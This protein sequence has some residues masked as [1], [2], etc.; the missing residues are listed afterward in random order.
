MSESSVPF[1]VSRLPR[2]IVGSSSPSWWGTTTFMV[3]EGMALLLCAGS[4]L[5]LARH[6]DGTPP[7]GVP[8]PDV[9]LPTVSMV[10]LLFTLWP[11]RLVYKAS[12]QRD[13][14]A[15]RNALLLL[16]LASLPPTVLRGFEFAALNV[17]WDTTAYGS[18]VWYILGF[19]ATLLVS[20]LVESLVFLAL[21]HRGTVEQ[22]HF[23]D[24]ADVA[25]Y[26]LF[27][28]LSWIPLWFLVY[29]V[30]RLW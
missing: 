21:F 26:D 5:Y 25:A 10:L 14:R 20:D 22:R 15:V 7:P 27:L 16:T 13:R 19:H 18:V 23:S 29:I 8:L 12:Q 17:Q 9:V 30:P 3:C 4:Y 2:T 6:W 24:T 1:D 11:A 28:V